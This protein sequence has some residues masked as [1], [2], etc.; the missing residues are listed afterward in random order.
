MATEGTSHNRDKGAPSYL[1]WDEIDATA[2]GCAKAT[3]NLHVLTQLGWPGATV[4]SPHFVVVSTHDF[5][6]F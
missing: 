5:E 3:F 4:D 6:Q 2:A 1:L